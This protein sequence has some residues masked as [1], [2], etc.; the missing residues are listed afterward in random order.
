MSGHHIAETSTGISQLLENRGTHER[1]SGDRRYCRKLLTFAC[2]SHD[3]IVRQNGE[4]FCKVPG[5][6]FERR[7]WWIGGRIGAYRDLEAA[8]TNLKSRNPNGSY[9]RIGN[10]TLSAEGER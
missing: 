5:K 9:P 4:I 10:S 1:G 3:M 6:C 2:N 7:G 8:C